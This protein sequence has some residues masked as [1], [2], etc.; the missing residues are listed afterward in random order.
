MV[1]IQSSVSVWKPGQA[2][3]PKRK[4][5]GIGCPTKLLR[6]D[7]RHNPMPVRELA[8]SWPSSAWKTVVWQ[9]ET[10]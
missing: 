6:H 9:E 10:P 1:G 5:K 7:R 3:L 2:P 8:M 4:W